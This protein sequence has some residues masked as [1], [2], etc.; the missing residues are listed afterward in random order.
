MQKA[1]FH[2]CFSYKQIRK[3]FKILCKAKLLRRTEKK[4]SVKYQRKTIFFLCYLFFISSHSP[5]HS[6][7]HS[8]IHSFSQSF[9]HFS[10][11]CKFAH[12]STRHL[13]IN[14]LHTFKP[15]HT[16]RHMHIYM[17]ARHKTLCLI[18]QLPKAQQQAFFCCCCC[19]LTASLLFMNFLNF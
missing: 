16:Y 2:A 5:L 18:W 9:I 6:F 14:T 17:S 12:T 7:S 15:K 10:I 13:Q 11:I 4:R 8:F 19:R 1:T 3:F